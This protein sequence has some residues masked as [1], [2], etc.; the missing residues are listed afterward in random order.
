MEEVTNT[1]SGSLMLFMPMHVV[2]S[3]LNM[4][5]E[6][7]CFIDRTSERLCIRICVQVALP[8]GTN[9]CFYIQGSLY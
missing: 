7:V 1:E 8:H 9:S 2:L 5:Q 6:K 3:H 4:I